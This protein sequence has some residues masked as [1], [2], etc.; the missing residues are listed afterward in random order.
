MI[1]HPEVLDQI[2]ERISALEKR[3]TFL[4][5]RPPSIETAAGPPVV[6]TNPSAVR[7]ESSQIGGALT[8]MGK[9]LLGMAGA[10]VLRALSGS[11]V[12]SGSGVM[13]RS[14]VAAIAVA[15]A[16]GWL[17]AAARTVSLHRLAGVLYAATS[18]LILA[19]MLWEMTLRFHV[20]P[21]W[22]AAAVVTAFG[23]VATGLAYS[24]QRSPVF[25]VAYAGCALTALALQ[26]GTHDMAP[27]AAILL[28]ILV[29]CEFGSAAHRGLALRVLV[30]LSADLAV[31]ILLFLYR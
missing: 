13:P 25:S 26:I 31:W 3:V 4:E 1:A 17:V 11:S 20:M 5:Q 19:P 2:V 24:P 29:V 9:S 30:A 15:Y 27:F 21:A 18:A 8:V 16:L 6:L 22:V 23:C 12:M 28:T 7:A 10:Y 14:L